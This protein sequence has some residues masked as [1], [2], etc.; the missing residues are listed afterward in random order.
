MFLLFFVVSINAQDKTVKSNESEFQT[1][2]SSKIEHGG[3]GAPYLGYTSV[4]KYNTFT[5]G[6]KGAWI[7]DHNLAL[8]IAGNGFITENTQNAFNKEKDA[9]IAGGYGGFLIEPIFYANK[10]VHFSVPLIIGGGAVTYVHE[11]FPYDEY[12]D[13][14][15]DIYDT[16]FVFE[17][18]IEL[19]MNMT[20]FFRIAIGLSYRFTS[21]IDLST[22]ML[23]NNI[24]ILGEKDMNQFVAR[25]VFKFGKF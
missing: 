13:Y 14:E 25:L 11:T 6:G 8:G 10:P 18:G 17:P 4:G 5:A 19:E 22:D 2:L 23:G 15:A 1:I 3:Y 12:H 7:M 20:T 9:F 16:F 24:E 21:N